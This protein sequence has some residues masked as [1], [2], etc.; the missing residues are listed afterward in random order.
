MMGRQV[1][2]CLSNGDQEALLNLLVKKL[3]IAA[4]LPPFISLPPRV[5]SP[6]DY[7]AWKSG[8]HDPH[9]FLRNDADSI[10]YREI[11]VLGERKFFIDQFKS[12]VI[13]FDRCITRST[14]I[15]PGRFYYIPSDI[16]TA[17]YKIEKNEAFI[18]TAQK[19]FAMTKN[20]AHRDATSI[21][22]VR[23]QR[24][25]SRKAME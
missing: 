6:L 20:F 14:G 19:V 4:I 5:S 12:P 17:G 8:E 9:I 22:L 7:S 3:D 11:N 1:N 25:C 13:E 24:R 15:R 16:D 23:R 21:T 10:V 18:R 2:F